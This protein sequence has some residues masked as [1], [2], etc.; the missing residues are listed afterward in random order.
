MMYLG[1][2]LLLAP[3]LPLD[4]QVL[5]VLVVSPLPLGLPQDRRPEKM[6]HKTEEIQ[7]HNL[8]LIAR[9][10]SQGRSLGVLDQSP[11]LKVQKESLYPSQDHPQDQ[12]VGRDLDLLPGVKRQATT[13]RK[14]DHDRTN[15]AGP[16]KGE[17]RV[18]ENEDDQESAGGL[19]QENA[20]DLVQ[21]NED[22][23]DQ[24][25]GEVEETVLLMVITR[26]TLCT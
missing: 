22:D 4:P 18:Q 19:D 9:K 12:E 8:D 10:G 7:D 20:E 3:T 15:E 1:H 25:R 2:D 23:P 6:T 24:E 14:K 26:G 21:E 16:K 11:R 13:E 17:D 5:H